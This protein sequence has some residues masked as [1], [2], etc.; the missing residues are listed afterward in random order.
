MN[1]GDGIIL[2]IDASN[3]RHGGGITH[4]SQL[5]NHADPKQSKIASV[6]VWSNKKTLDALPNEMWLKK[7]SD[8]LLEGNSLE[9]ILWQVTQLSKALKD[10][11]CGV[12]FVPGA[13]FLT[14]FK[15]IVT[16]HQNLLPFELN[17]ILRYGFSVLALKLL[18]LRLTQSVSFKRSSGIIFL[19]RYSKEVL[20]S[21]IDI[22]NV[23]Y[24]I[25][26]HGVEKRFRNKPKEQKHISEYSLEK[27]YKIIYVSSVDLYKHQWN[28]VEAVSRLRKYGYPVSLDLYGR[29]YKRALPLLERAMKQFDPN[30]D[31]I[32]LH[33]E[34]PF[35]HIDEVYPTADLSVFAS[36]CETFGQIIIESIASGLP[37]CC[38]NM[39]SMPELL[40]SHAR[41]FDPLDVDDIE[42]CLK[43]VIDSA[44]MR[45]E[46]S[47]GSFNYA[48][49]FSWVSTSKKSFNF[50]R[51]IYESKL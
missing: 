35:K 46:L 20:N 12:L 2:G 28:V 7:K 18:V 29:A 5:L 27:P 13:S 11:S 34:I 15:P 41:Y 47:Y 45:T 43:D 44:K 31:F 49:Q 48:D 6:V 40:K 8:P 16:M 36:S 39:S 26:P 37:V 25:I 21:K 23:T 9:R 14:K 10:E 42:Y 32:T 1:L 3:I 38:S 30:G 17:E 51:K 24:E 33:Q 19:S 22:K 4:L 50:F